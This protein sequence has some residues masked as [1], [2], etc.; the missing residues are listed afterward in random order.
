MPPGYEQVAD[1]SYC[2]E[3]KYEDCKLQLYYSDQWNTDPEILFGP[4]LIT[5]HAAQARLKK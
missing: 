5:I 2:M 4:L 1:D 3:L